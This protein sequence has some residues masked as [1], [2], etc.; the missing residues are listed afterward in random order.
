MCATKRKREKE[1]GSTTEVASGTER[2]NVRESKGYADKGASTVR[3]GERLSKQLEC[4][5]KVTRS[6]E[7]KRVDK[8]KHIQR[9]QWG[10]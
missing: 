5:R 1:R 6:R 8:Q 2:K 10:I 3:E 4:L 9:R 7:Q